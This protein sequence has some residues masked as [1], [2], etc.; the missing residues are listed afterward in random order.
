[1]WV[2]AGDVPREEMAG[3]TKRGVNGI[4][5]NSPEVMAERLAEIEAYRKI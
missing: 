5:S 1:V 4:I 2:T 3:L